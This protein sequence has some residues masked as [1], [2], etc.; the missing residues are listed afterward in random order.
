MVNEPTSL[1]YLKALM[2]CAEDH[3]VVNKAVKT[4][5]DEAEKTTTESQDNPYQK[6]TKKL[7]TEL[8]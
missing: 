4:T 2:P 8:T 3:H 1:P 5:V 6:P 7:R